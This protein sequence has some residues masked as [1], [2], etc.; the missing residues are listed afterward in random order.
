METLS[1]ISVIYGF[2]RS[3]D[4]VLYDNYMGHLINLYNVPNREAFINYVD[5]VFSEIKWLGDNNIN[6]L[7]NEFIAN[8]AVYI[9]RNGYDWTIEH[10]KQVVSG[11]KL[12]S[13]WYD[14]TTVNLLLSD[15]NVTLFEDYSRM[16]DAGIEGNV[17]M[18]REDTNF[19]SFQLLARHLNLPV[20]VILTE[21]NS[22]L[23]N[24]DENT[25]RFSSA[26][27]Y[28]KIKE[29][30]VILAGCG[31][32][33]SYVAF[34]LSRL[35]LRF[36]H[37]YD[38]DK[39]EGVNMAGQLYSYNDIGLYKVD[40]INRMIRNYSCY[41]STYSYANR[42]TVN[43]DPEKIMICGF[44]N[45]EARKVFFKKWKNF[46]S[47]LSS[48]ERKECLFLDGR[49]AAEEFQVFCIT[50]DD[51]YNMKKYESDYLFSDE[52]A[53]ETSCSYKQTTFMANMIGSIIVNLFVNFVANLVMPDLR[54][55]PF[56]INYDASTMTLGGSN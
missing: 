10:D 36:L 54:A 1:N 12:L 4:T 37:L 48:E 23:L 52:E 26:V 16:L 18:G 39:V 50:G 29:Q 45:M 9:H 31:G 47:S 19:D 17:I 38:N 56:Y 40:A 42:F 5:R 33:G 43:S 41:Y 51:E 24:F 11:Y 15:V 3:E 27:W 32:I 14:D 35:Q 8:L 34:L 2:L 53:E 22:Q 30:K 49:L 20:S 55:L 13:W 44:D 6:E 7:N 21:T 25:A 28:E 46:V